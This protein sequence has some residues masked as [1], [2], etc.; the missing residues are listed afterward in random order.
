MFTGT[1]GMIVGGRRTSSCVCVASAA[2]RRSTNTISKRP[3]TFLITAGI[4]LREDAS[5]A[6][7]AAAA[8]PW[9]HARRPCRRRTGPGARHC[10]RGSAVAATDAAAG[11]PFERI[12]LP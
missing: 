1:R 4:L 6:C 10:T 12:L 3:P 7:R 11:Y 8:E 9:Q 2:G 5:A